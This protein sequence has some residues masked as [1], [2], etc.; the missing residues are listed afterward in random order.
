MSS[1]KLLNQDAELARRGVAVAMNVNA[2]KG[3]MEVL[4]TNLGPK[5]TLKMLVSGSGDIKITKDGNTLLHEMQIQNPTAAMIART[6]T[7]QDDIC[8]DGTTSSVIFIGELL[9]QAERFLSE[10]VH[11]RVIGDGFDIAKNEALEF[12]EKFKV[13]KDTTDRELLLCIAKTSLRTKVYAELADH[14]ADAVVD[15]ILCIRKKDAPIDLFMVEVMTMQHKSD[16]ESRL[17]NGLVLDHGA[18]HP[19]MRKRSEN[20]YILTCN[21]SMEYEKSEV[22]SG[23][24]YS[25]A[26]QREKLV[27]AERKFT[28]DRVRKVIEL[29][30]TVCGDSGKGFVV[31]NQKG[32]D[33]L[34]LDMLAKEGI[35]GIRR[36][37]RRNM[38]RLT[39]ACG[40]VAVNSFDELQPSDLGWADVVY[41]QTLGDDKFTFVEGTQ[42]PLSCTM[43]LK[44]PNKHTIEQ[45]KD[46]CRDGLRAVKNAVEDKALLPGAGAFEVACH[47]HLIEFAKTVSGRAKLGVQ[48][49]AEALLI[50]PKTLAVNSGFDPQ[51]SFLKLQEAYVKG[52]TVGLDVV[53]GEAMDPEAEG[54]YDNYNVK[55]Q[56]LH[57]SAVIATQ[58]L[59]VDEVMRA[60]HGA[61]GGGGGL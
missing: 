35:I 38:E 56:M 47:T 26:E 10:G 29:K 9:K 25:S 46:A 42:N 52:L 44:G 3:L 45:I 37:K 22:N 48:A 11:P 16:L 30:R 2:A 39:L 27:E 53:T 49:F 20:C 6:A 21:V 59:L 41:E 24:F 14:L 32:I 23:F 12:L 55:A 7:A 8:G 33:P 17:V 28:D 43:L 1:L 31:I 61:R 58:L 5:G 15:A 40:G 60:G 54:V 50:I 18:R 51:D 34:S 4:K 19:D 57:S 13:V 36:A